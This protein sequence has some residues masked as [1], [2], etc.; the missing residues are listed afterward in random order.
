MR[1]VSPISPA[2][3]CLH[4]S[5]V[6]TKLL[7]LVT[8]GEVFTKT[9]LTEVFFSATKLFQ[10]KDPSLRRWVWVSVAR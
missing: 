7:Y 9:E 6:I 5:Q 8:Q 10:S 2:P 3:S 4:P 1:A